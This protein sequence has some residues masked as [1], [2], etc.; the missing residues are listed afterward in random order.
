MKIY[1]HL[2]LITINLFYFVSIIHAQIPPIQWSKCFGGSSSDYIVDAVE[3]KAGGYVLGCNTISNDGDVTGVHT[4]GDVWVVR[5]DINGNIIWEKS[6]GGSRGESLNYIEETI[7]SG[8][9]F[10]ALS[11][12]TD[13]DVSSHHGGVDTSD[14]WIVKLNKHGIIEWEKSFGGSLFD[15]PTA[16]HQTS[17]GNYIISGFSNSYDGDLTYNHGDYDFWVLKINVGGVLIWQKTYGGLGEEKAYSIIETDSLNF[18][19]VGSANYND[20]DV[21]GIHNSMGYMDFWLLKIDS[22]GNIIWSNAFGGTLN[23]EAYAISKV[24]WGG[25]IVGGY[26]RSHD[27]DVLNAYMGNNTS[28]YWIVKISENG[29]LEWQKS[30]G[31]SNMDYCYTLEET[32][33]SSLTMAG[34]STS[35]DYDVTGNHGGIGDIWVVNIDSLGNIIWQNCWGG[36]SQE[37]GGFVHQEL[38]GSLYL[39]GNSNSLDGDVI[40]LH[41][42]CDAWFVKL[43]N[44]NGI[45]NNTSTQKSFLLYPNPAQDNVEILNPFNGGEFKNVEYVKLFNLDGRLIFSINNSHYISLS[46]ISSGIYTLEVKCFNSKQS[47]FKLIKQ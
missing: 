36:S 13:G 29:I 44:L 12:S 6:F 38:D 47:Y 45:I 32:S 41:G 46:D 16:I 4:L 2:L 37:T 1:R 15:S 7:D 21:I 31:G 28:D 27:G 19:I 17:D 14:I 18:I 20:G 11:S 33:G 9:I 43:N 23:D 30:F 39:G 40:G 24:S 42:G 10:C 34:M 26:A 5:I 8:Y 35:Y 3:S 25:Y 22:I